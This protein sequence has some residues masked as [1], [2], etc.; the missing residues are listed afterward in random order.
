ME[1]LDPA[2]MQGRGGRSLDWALIALMTC[3]KVVEIQLA[4]HEA[5]EFS[6]LSRGGNYI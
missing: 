3:P 1:V 5:N 2:P 4:Q 6:W